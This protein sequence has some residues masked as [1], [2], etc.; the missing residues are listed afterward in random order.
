MIIRPKIGEDR[1]DQFRGTGKLGSSLE[2]LKTSDPISYYY[3]KFKS[4]GNK[5]LRDDMWTESARRGESAILA[6]ILSKLETL[7]DA[8][9]FDSAY[10]DKYQQYENKGLGDYDTYMLAL[11]IPTLNNEN[12]TERTDPETGYSFGEYTDREWAQ[13]VLNSTFQRYDAEMVEQKKKEKNWWERMWTEIGTYTATSIMNIVGGTAEFLGD[14]YNLGEGLLNMAFNWSDDA[15][16]GDRFLYAF[17][18]DQEDPGL[19]QQTADYMDEVSYLMQ[20]KYSEGVN[21]VEAYEA[22]YIP[23]SWHDMVWTS[24]WRTEGN[25]VYDNKFAEYWNGATKAIGYMIP[26]II[27][28]AVTGGSGSFLMYTGMASGTMK[29]TV[30]RAAE[31]G[32]SYKDLDAGQVV[33]NAIIKAGVQWAIEI[34]LSKVLGFFTTSERLRGMGKNKPAGAPSIG[35]NKFTSTLFATG[36]LLKEMGKE[37]LEEAL[38]DLSDGIIDSM[39]GL[40]NGEI[41]KVFAERGEE[42]IKFEN[43][44][45]SFIIG[46]MTEGIVATTTSAV[47]NTQFLSGKNRFLMEGKDGKVTKMGYFQSIAFNDTL[48]LMNGWN[49]TLRDPNA[50]QQA[51]TE[52]ARN[53]QEVMQPITSL[54]TTFSQSDMI[55]ANAIL[56]EQA[57]GE[58]KAQAIAKLTDTEYVTKL[59]DSFIEARKELAKKY[60]PSE[61]IKQKIKRGITNLIDKFKKQKV[62]KLENI[63]TKEVVSDNTTIGDDALSKLID[64]LDKLGVEALVGVDG[65]IIAKSEDVAFVNNKILAS[66]DIAEIVKGIAYQQVRDTVRTKLSTTQKNRILKTYRQIVGVDGTLEDAITA[67]L[68]D[69]NFY[70]KVLLLTEEK[71]RGNKEDELKMLSTIDNLI[72]SKASASVANGTLTEGA[73]KVLLNKVYETMRTGLINYCTN[74]ARLNLGEISNDILSPELKEVISNHRNV[75][76]SEQLDK[77]LKGEVLTDRDL[78]L[79]DD[80]VDKFTG[81]FTAEVKAS[82]KQKARSTN[83]NDRVDAFTIMTIASK[84]DNYQRGGDKIVYIPTSSDGIVEKEYIEKLQD[85]FGSDYMSIVLGNYD[86]TLITEEARNFIT[87]GYKEGNIVNRYDLSNKNDR[88]A[89]MREALYLI[90]HSTLTVGAD[91][92]LLKIIDKEGFLK[93]EYLGAEGDTKFKTDLQKG[94]IKTVS[95][96][97][98]KDVK[99]PDKIRNIKFEIKAISNLNGRYNFDTNSIEASINFNT[100]SLMHEITHATQFITGV[101][102]NIDLQTGGSVTQFTNLPN[103]V[104]ESLDKY[105][106]DNF[107]LSY[108]FMKAN[109]TTKFNTPNI[110]YFMLAGEI[111]ARSTLTTHMFDVGFTYRNKGAELVSPDGKQTWSLSTSKLKEHFAARQQS[112]QRAKE[113]ASSYESKIKSSDKQVAEDRP[114]EE[115]KKTSKKKP[116]VLENQISMFKGDT[117]E[118]NILSADEID[119]ARKSKKFRERYVSQAKARQSNLKYGYNKSS[120][121]LFVDPDVQKFVIATTEEFDKLD[122]A[123]QKMIKPNL[124]ITKNTINNYVA[125]TANMNDYTFKMIAKY[126]YN[127]EEL[128]KLTFK[129]FI[130]LRDKTSELAMLSYY[131]DNRFKIQSPTDMYKEEALYREK[132]KQDTELQKK[133][134]K[135]NEIQGVDLKTGVPVNI[136]PLILN[137]LYFNKYNGTLNSIFQIS[138]LAKTLTV[139]ALEGGELAIAA[140]K[141]WEWAERYKKAEVDYRDYDKQEARDEIINSAKET[142]SQKDRVDKEN[143]ILAYE[144]AQ[145]KAKEKTA[146]TADDIDDLRMEAA[147]KLRELDTKFARAS[148]EEIDAMYLS[149]LTNISSL[150]KQTK[151]IKPVETKQE[152]FEFG[153]KTSTRKNIKDGIRNYAKAFRELVLTEEQST[154]TKNNYNELPDNLKSVI[155]AENDYKLPVSYYTNMTDEQLNTL[156]N[157]LINTVNKIKQKLKR[158]KI[159]EKQRETIMEKAD[160]QQKQIERYKEQIKRQKEEIEY[161]KRLKEEAREDKKTLR[162]KLVAGQRRWQT[163]IVGQEFSFNSTSE[164]NDIVKN[165]LNTTWSKT[166]KS[167]VQGVSNNE[168]QVIANGKEFFDQ[169]TTTLMSAELSQIE[170]AAK[171]FLGAKVDNMNL[172]DARIFEALN[173]Y[174]T[175]YVLSQTRPGNIYAN[176]NENLK[177]EIENHY[178]KIMSTSGTLLAIGNNL[179]PLIDP[180]GVMSAADIELDGVP[181]VGDLKT[182]LFDAVKSGSLEQMRAIINEIQQYVI[183]KRGTKRSIV[184]QAVTI[185][186]M[187]MLSG[188]L[189]WLRNTVSNIILKPLNKFFTWIGSKVM[190]SE[191]Y[192]Q[193]GQLK[194][195]KAITKEIQDFITKNFV[196]NGFFDLFI[197]NLSKYNPSDISE[198]KFKGGKASKEAI[199]IQLVLKSMYGQY[200]NENIF[201][202]KKPVG[203]VLNKLYHYLMKAMS[204]EKFV[205]EA[206]IRY[207]GKIIAEK[208]YSMKDAIVTDEI[209]NDLSTAIGLAMYDYMH[210]DNLLSKFEGDLYKK[211]PS[212]YFVYKQILP[213]APSGWNW[214]KSTMK[215]TP[216]GLFNAIKKLRHLEA[217]I[218]KAQKAWEE[219]RSQISPELTEYIIRRDIGAGVF[220]TTCM[221]FGIILAAMGIISLE[222]EDY[223]IPKIRIGNASFDVSTIYGS[224]SVLAGAAL[225]NGLK[226]EDGS[227][228]KALNNYT[229]FMLNDFFVMEIVKLDM[230]SDGT[231]SMGMDQLESIILSYIPNLLSYIAG[232]TYKGT[233]KKDKFW[234]RALSKIPFIANAVDK[235]IDPY[236]GSEGSWMEAVNRLVPYFSYNVAS[237]N[238]RKTEALGLNKE[239]LNGKYK[240]NGKDFNVKGK[241]LEAINKA[242]GQWNA[243]DLTKFYNNQM[244]VKVKVDDNHYRTLSYNQMTKEQRKNAVQT[245]MKNNAE[246]AKIMAWTQAGNKYFGSADTYVKLRKRGIT[247]G[248]YKGTKGFVQSK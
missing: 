20:Y 219:G 143:A 53:M 1:I 87:P 125:T 226:G 120:A 94:T 7:Q 225:M 83:M 104:L 147:Q 195:D 213:F 92:T 160:K 231:F 190:T 132:A 21:A 72:K 151:S 179:M 161:Q 228:L 244:R 129:E 221:I 15:N 194:L 5:Y 19:F 10:L 201:N 247:K 107:P 211:S 35:A 112:K 181:I 245:I 162:E 30:E 63:I 68:F 81:K 155:T 177:R 168:E 171:W 178:K 229:D 111:Q 130:E 123:I 205:R 3:E 243:E 49:N 222:D 114:I 237:K 199:M 214:F 170:E 17:S 11:S 173:L 77:G 144:L 137:T 8:E 58:Q 204:D 78:T 156:K 203:Q 27:F 93:P 210:S 138:N 197:S 242:Y 154:G 227:L 119:K 32:L 16:A 166:A 169:N 208:G 158:A 189:T 126:I 64:A 18:N 193:S 86:P 61:P 115:S 141:P 97:L 44:L 47:K 180:I 127:N 46:A 36:R 108:N 146:K 241:D 42:T 29:D 186:S 217:N 100:N 39:Y 2:Y 57:E 218:A 133:M 128:A 98:N 79:F 52:A 65:A 62:T 95:D 191:K 69:K 33:S 235:N 40:G 202:T 70:T 148:D 13:S 196:D 25:K 236:T 153:Q 207:F 4:S 122:S 176:M 238:E 165:I 22:G 96:I 14:I 84:I 140:G 152:E 209:M 85:F 90:S 163:N 23:N 51:K 71:S 105:I 220:G 12:K 66:G 223:G 240:I 212:L 192:T 50:T 41:N 101:G 233:T 102:E 124:D 56:L 182:R 248:V 157:D 164:P 118:L 230:Y 135:A 131:S 110:V 183:E 74:Y 38:Q 48:K 113:L 6:D 91:G 88:L 99:V 117:D 175:G 80:Y 215:M 187:S 43:L 150:N 60:V 172:E 109:K 106:S 121:P 89:C 76:F 136:D 234:K 206:A 232:G 59:Y 103:S 246:M 185:R 159:R 55:K 67:L 167:R 216:F 174:F 198:R 184:R 45:Q 239:Q 134:A 149:T 54:M 75:I 31:N 224:S 200:Y 82:I 37:G 145:I 116:K 9:D 24:N 28:A 73:Y 34:A 139:R 142:V 188:P 26:S